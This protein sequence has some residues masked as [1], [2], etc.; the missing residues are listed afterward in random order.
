MGFRQT[1]LVYDR[2]ARE[3]GSSKFNLWRLLSLAVDG[4]M[5]HS[6][7]PLRLAMVFGLGLS[8]VALIG[9]IYFIV[10]KVFFRTD[11]PIG[12]AT[13][14]VLILFSIGMNAVLLG[15]VGEYIGRIYKNVKRGPLTIVESIV[16]RF[17]PGDGRLGAEAQRSLLTLDRRDT[18]YTISSP[19]FNEAELHPM[20]VVILA[21]G[22]GTRIAEETSLRPKPMIEIGGLPLLLHVMKIYSH[23][24]YNDFV[25]CLGYMGYYIKEYFSNYS[26]HRT[27]VTYDFA[28]GKVEYFNNVAEPWRVSLVD[29]GLNTMTGGRLKRIR[30]LLGDD[31]FMLTYGDG[32]AD[33]DIR[34]LVAAHEAHGR[35]AT[36]TA[37]QPPGRFGSLEIDAAGQVHSFREKTADE[38]GLDQRRV[39]RPRAFGAR[40]DLGRRDCLGARTSGAPRRVGRTHR[41][42]S[43]WLLAAGRHF[44]RKEAAG[45]ALGDR[46]SSVA[47]GELTR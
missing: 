15:I 46:E 47:H 11:W 45:G 18:S 42:S 32:V 36:V 21:G 12:L 41:S 30:D 25:I 38:F 10:A 34:A 20:K 29:T 27:D 24:G 26:L 3:R 31:R 16:D 14:N 1:G 2:A 4:I 28:S 44:A 33:I 22:L 17:A 6:V 40:P 8:L 35:S 9:A 39:L 23:Y 19:G 5:H 37:V 13:I 7:V 43:Y